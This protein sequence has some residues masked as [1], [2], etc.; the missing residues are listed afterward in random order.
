MQ[1]LSDFLVK[2]Y[3]LIKFF[4]NFYL[5]KFFAMHRI[6]SEEFGYSSAWKRVFILIKTREKAEFLYIFSR[7][8]CTSTT[9]LLENRNP[10]RLPF[11]SIMKIQ[12]VY[13]KSVNVRNKSFK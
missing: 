9:H 2:K 10:F 5:K 11:S 4:R 8:F 12:K 13:E 6:F 7:N 3:F 1:Q